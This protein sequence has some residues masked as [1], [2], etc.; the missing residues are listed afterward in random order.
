MYLLIIV[1][2]MSAG[3][4]GP[5]NYIVNVKASPAVVQAS[6][7]TIELCEAARS[8]VARAFAEK[9]MAIASQGCHR[10]S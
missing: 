2:F 9:R 7:A 3:G 1:A 5:D 8:K 10:R 6:F 4:A